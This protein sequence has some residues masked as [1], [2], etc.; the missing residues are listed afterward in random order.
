MKSTGTVPCVPE[1]EDPIPGVVFASAPRW[2]PAHR[3]WASL[4]VLAHQDCHAPKCLAGAPR[5]GPGIRSEARSWVREM[6]RD[7][8]G[9]AWL[10]EHLDLCP[11]ATARAV[12]NRA[13]TY[14]PNGVVRSLQR[15]DYGN[16]RIGRFAPERTPP[17]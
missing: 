14:N 15:A 4:L 10:C 7:V 11:H 3:L 9:F 13:P 1:I 2:T 17:R 16:M 12:L 5:Q 8:G 6:G